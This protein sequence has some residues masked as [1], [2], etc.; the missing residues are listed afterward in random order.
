MVHAC[1]WTKLEYGFHYNTESV[2]RIDKRVP[3]NFWTMSKS[4]KKENYGEHASRKYISIYV[5]SQLVMIIYE[6]QYVRY[7]NCNQLR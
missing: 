6:A 2:G 5:V 1:S 7:R 4:A 3:Y